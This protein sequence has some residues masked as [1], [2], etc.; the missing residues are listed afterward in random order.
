MSAD[1]DDILLLESLLNV[2]FPASYRNLLA[3]KG[4]S[5]QSSA[6]VLGLPVSLDEDSV[7]GATEIVRASRPDLNPCLVAIHMTGGRALCLDLAAGGEEDAPVVSVELEDAGVTPTRVFD[8]LARYI[9]RGVPG[10][11]MEDSGGKWFEKGLARLDRHMRNLSFRYDH[12]KGGRLPRGHVWRPYRFCVQDVLLGVTVVRHDRKYNRLE[13]DVFLTA[14]MAEYEPDS[15][16]RALALIILSDAY[17]CGGSMEIKFTGNVEGGRVPEELRDLANRVGVWL[18][19]ADKGGVTPGE[20]RSL[21]LTLTGF[22]PEIREMILTMDKERKASA[23]GACYAVHHGVWTVPELEAILLSCRFPNTILRGGFP[24]EAWHLF[25]Y[26][27]LQV[28]NALLG[29][30]LDRRL[31]RRE[32]NLQEEEMAVVELEDDENA[33]EISFDADHHAKVYRLSEGDDGISIPWLADDSRPC[34]LLPGHRLWVLPRARDVEDLRRLLSRDLDRA[35]ALKKTR[36]GHGDLVCVM[37]P[38]DF[39]RLEMSEMVG[40]ASEHGIGLIVCPEFLNQLD[41]EASRGFEAVK[42]MRQ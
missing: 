42:V 27:L 37:V 2:R 41:R 7:W 21:Y 26:D 8:S 32:H 4:A 9:A 39:G 30:Y 17:K 12:K 29:G 14:S 15:G 6:P 19:H 38:G 24:P 5:V 31:R 40:R 36:A 23:A 11:R 25:H 1:S 22:R 35:V 10:H 16:C 34:T 20:A 28:R 18:A 13:V 33:V 3:G